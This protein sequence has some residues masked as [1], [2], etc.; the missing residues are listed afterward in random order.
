MGE[1]QPRHTL[2][3]AHPPRT[4]RTHRGSSKPGSVSS[5]SSGPSLC[6]YPSRPPPFPYLDDGYLLQSGGLSAHLSP[7]SRAFPVSLAQRSPV[8]CRSLHQLLRANDSPYAI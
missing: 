8:S 3:V 4:K 2:S 6:H 7:E 1:D 5:A